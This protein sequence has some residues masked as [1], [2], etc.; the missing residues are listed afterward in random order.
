MQILGLITAL[1]LLTV[2]TF[3]SDQ[4][5]EYYASRQLHKGLNHYTRHYLNATFFDE[6][7][8]NNNP[9]IITTTTSSTP[10]PE[11]Y[12]DLVAMPLLPK[13]TIVPRLSAAR[14]HA[15]HG[16][17]DSHHTFSFASYH[18]P[19]YASFGSLRVL[20]EDRVAAHRGFDTH[21]HRDA[22]I[23]S[24][25]LSGQLTHRDSM[26][27]KGREV[28]QDDNFYRMERGDVQFTT[29]GT[30]IAHS[31][32]NESDKE[33]HFLQIWALPWKRGL[34]PRYHTKTFTEEAKME[35]FVPILSP[36]QAGPNA[37][38]EEEKA[39]TPAVE[40][41][42][43][44]HADFVMAAGIIGAGKRFKYTVGGAAYGDNVVRKADRRVYIHLPMTKKGAAQIRLDGRDSAVLREGDGAFI[45]G[46]K[47]GD[48]LSV[49][50][51]GEAKAE[52]IVLDSD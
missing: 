32:Q 19:L 33:V 28:K 49:E 39:A 25:I 2:S 42:I 37:S 45:T 3:Y 22:E 14:G 29:G 8:K 15:N 11:K 1:I 16:W 26:Q 51:V 41:T 4:L 50:S 23:F 52:V 27:Q 34:T 10:T 36:L 9:A 48:V 6:L 30:G 43:P 46:V 13:A 31:E 20:N 12:P 17:L 40:G 44:I 21:P 18:D 7:L 5:Y 38:A 24:Y 47:V 35:K